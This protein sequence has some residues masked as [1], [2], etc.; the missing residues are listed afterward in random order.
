MKKKWEQKGTIIMGYALRDC[1]MDFKAS[2]IPLTAD[3]IRE[4]VK[5]IADALAIDIRQN[6]SYTIQAYG[7][8]SV[9]VDFA[10]HIPFN[11][12]TD[13]IKAARAAGFRVKE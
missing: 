9:S 8:S 5:G 13:F 7:T 4:A 1:Y 10:G 6:G 2:S 12:M 11:K 3:E